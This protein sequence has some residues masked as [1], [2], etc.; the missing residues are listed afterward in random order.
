[1][2]REGEQVPPSDTEEGQPKRPARENAGT[3]RDRPPMELFLKTVAGFLG[4]A[5][6]FR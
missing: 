3:R 1:M 6:V 4:K 5:H 2:N